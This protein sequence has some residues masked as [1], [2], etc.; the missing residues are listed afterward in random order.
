MTTKARSGGIRDEPTRIFC[1]PPRI[2]QGGMEVIPTVKKKF[3]IGVAPLVVSAAFVL[4]P[5]ASQGACGTAPNC[6]HTYKNGLILGE[7]KKLLT[8]MWGQ[9][10]LQNGLVGIAVCQNIFAGVAE[11]PVGGGASTGLVSASFPFECTDA[12]CLTLGGKFIE[13]IPEHL[14]WK[15][16]V[17]EPS[18]GVF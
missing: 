16:E 13:L 18:A 9:T 14:P 1:S 6:P 12:T 8:M 3:L 11:N 10:K 4:I 5:A 2:A 17:T 15:A 7:G